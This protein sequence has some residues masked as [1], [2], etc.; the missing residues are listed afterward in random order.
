MFYLKRFLDTRRKEPAAAAAA[1]AA[2]GMNPF[3]KG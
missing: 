3:N 2:W 1:A